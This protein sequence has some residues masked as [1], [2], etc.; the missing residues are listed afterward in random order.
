MDKLH[1]Y[2]FFK[3]KNIFEK[4]SSDFNKNSSKRTSCI[5]LILHAKS[6]YIATITAILDSLIFT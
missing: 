2:L 4:N 5:D 1:H 3:G 6:I